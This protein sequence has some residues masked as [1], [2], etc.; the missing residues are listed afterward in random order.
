M[1]MEVFVFNLILDILKP[2][3]C[4]ASNIENLFKDRTDS[5]QQFIQILVLK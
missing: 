5:T 2:C 1:E 3:V 4:I